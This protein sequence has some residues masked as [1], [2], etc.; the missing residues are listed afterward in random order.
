MLVK[1]VQMLKT[2]ECVQLDDGPLLTSWATSEVNGDPDNEILQVSWESEG[3]LYSAKFTERGVSEGRFDSE[4]A[5]FILED[6]EGS[7]C[8]LRLYT[9]TPIRG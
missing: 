2:A 7:E 5:V 3:L 8:R 4:P 6:A 9:L 1:F